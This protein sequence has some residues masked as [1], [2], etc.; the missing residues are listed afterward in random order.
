MIGEGSESL[1]LLLV[2]DSPADVF[3]IR[4][5]MQEAGLEFSLDVAEDGE[6]AIRMISRVDDSTDSRAP[7]VILIDVNVPRRSGNEVLERVRQSP[8]CACVPVIM[9]S[10]SD[11]AAERRRAFDLGATEYFCKPSSLPEF[12]KLGALVRSLHEAAPHPWT[13]GSNAPAAT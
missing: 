8:R 7:S 12:M 9:I 3:L 6:A 5:A 11:S 13:A 2:E 1:S 4:R 10:S